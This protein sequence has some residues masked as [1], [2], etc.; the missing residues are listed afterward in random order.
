MKTKSFVC[1]H[2]FGN[3]PGGRRP[4]FSAALRR[5]VEER[6]GAPVLWKEVLWDGLL[7]SPDSFRTMDLPLQTPALVRAFYEGRAGDV[8][9]A[10]VAEAVRAAAAESDGAPVVLVGHSF[11]AAIAYE[12]LARGLAPEAKALVMLAPPMALFNDPGAF[13]SKAAE[14]LA[15]GL[16]LLAGAFSP[17]A[18]AVADFPEV[19]GGRLPDDVSALSLRSDADWFAAPL[20]GTFPDVSEREVLPPPGTRGGANHRFYWESPDVAESVAAAAVAAFSAAGIPAATGAES[21]LLARAA[22][23]SLWSAGEEVEVDENGEEWHGLS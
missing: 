4:G 17:V 9:R 22:E 7:G 8:V 16:G 13:A 18:G 15:P 21:L 14:S 19:R 2:G 1:L 11:G 23:D 10:R 3:H 12:T 20:G 5:A 6:L